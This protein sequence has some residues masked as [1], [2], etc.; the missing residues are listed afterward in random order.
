PGGPMTAFRTHLTMLLACLFQ[1]VAAQQIAFERDSNTTA[2]YEE[3]MAHYRTLDQAFA[4]CTLLTCGPTDSGE[5][6]HLFVLSKDGL[7]DPKQVHEQAKPVILIN[8]GI[9]PGEPEGIDASMMLT[10]DLLAN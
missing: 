2:T 5:P 8:N 4:A 9:H 10:R 3:V 7:F 1:Q 6:L